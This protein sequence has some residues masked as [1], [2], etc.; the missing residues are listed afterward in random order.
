L[1][2]LMVVMIALLMPTAAIAKDAC[3]A[4]REKF[5]K[6]VIDA[7]GKVWACMKQH[8]AELSEACKTQRE[9]SA[10]CKADREKFCKDATYVGACLDYHTA[11]LSD[12]C[13][14]LRQA[15]ANERDQ[16]TAKMGKDEGTH[17][18]TNQG[19]K[20]ESETNKVDQPIRINPPSND[21][22]KD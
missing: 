9:A 6:D 16:G 17:T 12:A 19:T 20:P 15:M 1:K 5:C 18:R 4:D 13:R 10:E 3:K 2:P 22:T 8:Q 14:A 21:A 11:E 7:K